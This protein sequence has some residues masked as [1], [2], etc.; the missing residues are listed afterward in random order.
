MTRLHRII[1]KPACWSTHLH[2]AA[3]LHLL[4]ILPSASKRLLDV[5]PPLE[6]DTSENPLRD[7]SLLL[8]P[9]RLETDGTV[10][11]PDGPGLGVT[12]DEEK[13]FRYA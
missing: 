13:L 2:I 3:T 9:I 7:D 11:V 5:P 10:V 12:V 4:A 8:E 1:Y 6:F